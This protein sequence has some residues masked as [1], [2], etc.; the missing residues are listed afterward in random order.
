MRERFCFDYSTP[1][2]K[3]TEQKMKTRR[4]DRRLTNISMRTTIDNE[5]KYA[6]LGKRILTEFR[7][8]VEKSNDQANP[9]LL[10]Q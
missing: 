10:K 8:F 9:E 7:S 1:D 2:R 4:E 3:R 6:K 5:K